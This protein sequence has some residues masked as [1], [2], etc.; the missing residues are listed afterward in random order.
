MGAKGYQTRQNILHGEHRAGHTFEET[1]YARESRDG[2]SH[3]YE[4]SSIMF[5]VMRSSYYT[6]YL[7]ACLKQNQRTKFLQG[8]FLPIGCNITDL[9]LHCGLFIS[10]LWP[11]WPNCCKFH[12][13]P[14]RVFL[15]FCFCVRGYEFHPGP[16]C[17]CLSFHASTG[18]DTN[19]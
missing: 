13:S 5:E 9:N 17:V 15:S 7:H 10:P 18:F 16:M 11:L 1:E 4:A 19:F 2:Y 3:V 8:S 12:L 14:M 6:V